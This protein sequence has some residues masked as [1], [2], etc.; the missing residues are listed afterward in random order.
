[1]PT[2]L[3]DINTTEEIFGNNGESD[4]GGNITKTKK[5]EPQPVSTNKQPSPVSSYK[6]E[7]TV[8]SKGYS[9]PMMISWDSPNSNQSNPTPDTS[10]NTY[11]APVTTYNAAAAAP[12]NTKR[13]LAGY[14][15]PCEMMYTLQTDKP[16]NPI[17][18]IL[19]RDF[20]KSGIVLLP[21]GSKLTGMVTE[22]SNSGRIFIAFNRIL[23][24]SGEEKEFKGEGM[25][26]VDTSIGLAGEYINNTAKYAGVA[27][28]VVVAAG[29]DSMAQSQQTTVSNGVVVA[30]TPQPSF[31]NSLGKIGGQVV[32]DMAKSQAS[33]I[34]QQPAVYRVPQGKQL[35][36]Y[37]RET[38][39]L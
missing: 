1:M 22:V 30:T 34:A 39:T 32:G 2:A 36:I 31:G 7:D 33:Q 5:T 16:A 27:A 37:I 13:L 21:K 11:A 10:A 20:V 28:D 18:A 12:I 15:I 4:I 17:T 25:D 19:T 38:F 26:G 3:Q 14:S 29:L 6:D 8:S 35:Y 9:K 24:P 23:L